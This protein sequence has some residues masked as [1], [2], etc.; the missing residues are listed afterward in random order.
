M[1][2]LLELGKWTYGFLWGSLIFLF[3]CLVLDVI[4][5]WV[6]S[7]WNPLL[8]RWPMFSGTVSAVAYSDGATVF[9]LM[10]AFAGICRLVIWDRT[11]AVF[12]M[13]M[14]HRA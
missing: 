9:V 3:F 6:G 2:Y 4:G 5:F 7:G 10:V 11:P 14:K 8:G 13:W 12:V 1:K